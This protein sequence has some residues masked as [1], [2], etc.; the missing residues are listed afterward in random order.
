MLR[1]VACFPPVGKNPYSERLGPTRTCS[2]SMDC[3]GTVTVRPRFIDTAL[4]PEDLNNCRF[5]NFP[6]TEG[7]FISSMDALALKLLFQPRFAVTQ[8]TWNC[9]SNNVNQIKE[10]S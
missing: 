9:L 5:F 7:V 8:F 10:V 6:L 1:A 2:S 3:H 4:L